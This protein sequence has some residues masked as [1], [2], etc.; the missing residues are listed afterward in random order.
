MDYLPLGTW[1]QAFASWFITNLLGTMVVACFFSVGAFADTNAR[2]PVSGVLMLSAMVGGVA[3]VASLG[4]VPVG[5][6]VF[7]TV[8]SAKGRWLRITLAFLAVVSC[9]GGALLL[10]SLLSKNMGRNGWIGAAPYFLGSL[11]AT[12]K[13]YGKGLM[14]SDSF[15]EE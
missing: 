3:A 8:L 9:F 5:Y 12:A 1:R 10:L 11:A 4:M 7:S 13:V 15:H 6:M 14:R 2:H